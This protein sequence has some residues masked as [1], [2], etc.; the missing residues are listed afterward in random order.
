MVRG[1]NVGNEY[2]TYKYSRDI[3]NIV[4]YTTGTNIVAPEEGPFDGMGMMVGIGVAMEGFKGGKWLWNNKKDVKG[5]WAKFVADSKI[6]A[7]AFKAAGGL[8]NIDTY[9]MVLREH[10]AKAIKEMVPQGDKFTNLSK[11]TQGL[12]KEAVSATELAT[13]NPAQTKEAFKLA[14]EKLAQAGAKAHVENINVPAKGFFGKIGRAISKYSGASY[15]NGQMKTL[16]TK[17]PLTAKLLKYGKGNGLFL[18]ITG[19]VELFTQVIPAFGLGADKGVKQIGKSAARTGASIGGWVVGSAIAAKGGAMAGAAIGSIVPGV[20]TVVGGVV[21]SL[22]G[23]VGG[24]LGSWA[25][26]K[27]VNGVVGENETDKAKNK[28][29]QQVA[30]EAG[31]NPEEMQ[32]LVV[33]AAQKLQAEG[34]QSDDAKIA[35]KS[36]QKIAPVVMAQAN[37]NQSQINKNDVNF[38]G[39]SGNNPF[40]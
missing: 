39:N 11:E 15:L 25:A 38:T 17:S 5:A 32:Q 23:L 10:S 27:A 30:S 1:I 33:A 28:Q 26:T 19:A 9:K 18:A 22:I 24:C 37:E 40:A 31:Q 4:K 35:F 29:A 14:N 13:K 16:A 8:K 36:L 20:G 12:Y 3:E 6:Q 21:G 34:I 2:N 7:D